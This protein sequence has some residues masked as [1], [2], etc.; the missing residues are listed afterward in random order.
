[1]ALPP[2]LITLKVAKVKFFSDSLLSTLIDEREVKKDTPPK[3]V[4]LPAY[5]A[6]LQNNIFIYDNSICIP[7]FGKEG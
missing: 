1:V 2:A 7:L 5:K 6:G 3:K 4:K